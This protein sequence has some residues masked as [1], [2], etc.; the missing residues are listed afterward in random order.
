MCALCTLVSVCVGLWV[1]SCV[2]VFACLCPGIIMRVVC[3]C[4]RVA[5]ID[6]HKSC[7][8]VQMGLVHCCVSEP[9]CV[10]V[11]A[12]LHA[13]TCVCMCVCVFFLCL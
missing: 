6:G 4:A 13:C 12:C 3:V 2:S 1:R 9:L 5:G 7:V 8:A 10:C 11:P